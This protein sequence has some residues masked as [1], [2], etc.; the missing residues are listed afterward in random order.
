M[1]ATPRGPVEVMRQ[2]WRSQRPGSRWEWEWVARRGGQRESQQGSTAREAIRRATLTPAG[3]HPGW[4]TA[5][6]AEAERGVSAQPTQPP[7][8]P[9]ASEDTG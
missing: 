5:A 3:K 7:P 6:V 9:P 4:L 2:Q 1:V 8:D